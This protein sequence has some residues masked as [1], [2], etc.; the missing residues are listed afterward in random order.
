M[1]RRIAVDQNV[2]GGD[3]GHPGLKILNYTKIENAHKVSKNMFV[4]LCGCY[5]YNYWGDRTDTGA[6]MINPP[7]LPINDDARNEAHIAST[8]VRRY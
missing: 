3:G 1:S 7:E 8:G 4:L 2:L 5:M 6:V